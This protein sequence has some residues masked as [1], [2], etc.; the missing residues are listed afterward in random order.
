[1]PTNIREFHRAPT[2]ARVL[3]LLQRTDTPASALVISPRLPDAPFAHMAAVVDLQ[4]LALNTI[5]VELHLNY[6]SQPTAG[7]DLQLTG[8]P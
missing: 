7:F 4:A 3:E 8:L 5:A 2:S 6:K 1:M